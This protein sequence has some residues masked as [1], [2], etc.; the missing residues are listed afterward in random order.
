[1]FKKILLV[2]LLALPFGVFA[3][4]KIA[5]VNTQEILALMPETKAAQVEMEKM[6]K[7]I[8]S[9]LKTLEDEFAKKYQTFVQ[10]SDTLVESIKIRRTTELNEI[11]QRMETY[12]E[13]A[14]QHIYTKQNDLMT[15]IHQKLIDTIKTVGEENGYA[16]IMQKEAF[17]FIAETAIDATPLVKKKL[18]L[19]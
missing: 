1:M 18:G 16:Y 13:E 15:P 17:I 11:R 5:F 7:Q 9:E 6:G 19:Q 12:R 10:Q 4:D 2:A 3:Q 14:Q 8:D